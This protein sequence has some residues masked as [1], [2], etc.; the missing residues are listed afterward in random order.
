M[1]TFNIILAIILGVMLS[2]CGS[3]STAGDVNGGGNSPPIAQ[4]TF[5]CVTSGYNATTYPAGVE[6]CNDTASVTIP[7]TSDNLTMSLEVF[8]NGAG[9]AYDVVVIQSV[10]SKGYF[11]NP[12]TEIVEVHLDANGTGQVIYTPTTTGTDHI[13]LKSTLLSNGTAAEQLYQTT[14]LTLTIE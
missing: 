11:G 1:K 2:A 6:T 12:G 14:T 4:S 3:S 10:N 13:T 7:T 8:E 5:D 9:A